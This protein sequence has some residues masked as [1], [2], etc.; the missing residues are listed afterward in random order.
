MTDSHTHIYA[1]E[2]DADRDDVVR[3]ARH[4][5]VACAI[6]PNEDLA[7]VPRLISA[8][9]RYPDF[10]HLALGLH[11][12]AVRAD[13]ADTLNRLEPLLDRYATHIVAI[14]EVGLDLYWDRTFRQ[15]QMLAL[16]RQL[17]WCADRQLP[18]IIHCREALNELLDVLDAFN[19]PLPNGVMHCFGGTADDVRRLRQRA[20]FHFGIGGTVTFKK[21]TLPDVLPVIGLDRIVLETDAPYLAPVPHRGQ[22]NECAFLTHICQAVAHALHTDAGTV[23]QITDNNCRALFN[24]N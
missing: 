3:R 13:W 15:E 24:L 23:E 7:S 5:G 17:H 14:G 10:V 9:Q 1:E 20:D 12:E 22:R 11:P 4:A 2:F 19:G 6:L 21:S 8:R 18:V 16:D